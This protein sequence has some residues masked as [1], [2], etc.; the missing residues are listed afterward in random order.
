MVSVSSPWKAAGN[1]AAGNV[2]PV[3]PHPPEE[4]RLAAQGDDDA[5][6]LQWL[7]QG[8]VPPGR[9]RWGFFRNSTATRRTAAGRSFST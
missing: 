1:G 6:I 9:P 8:A 2:P 3:W 4:H 7:R 5:R